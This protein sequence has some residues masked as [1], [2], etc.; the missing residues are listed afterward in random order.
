MSL[1]LLYRYKNI[2]L[3]LCFTAMS[4]TLGLFPPSPLPPTTTAV[5]STTSR[6][7]RISRGKSFPL[8]ETHTHGHPQCNGVLLKRLSAALATSS[9][10]HTL[11]FCPPVTLLM[12][13]AEP[14]Q[15][16]IMGNSHGCAQ[17]S[18]HSHTPHNQHTIRTSPLE[19]W[20]VWPFAGRVPRSRKDINCYTLTPQQNSYT[21]SQ[22]CR[23]V[24]PFPA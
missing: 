8:R 13:S 6:D 2:F 24:C 17:V 20:M 23:S 11:V 12:D 10:Y 19:H 21:L 5:A 16:S 1:L 14:P 15:T 4:E 7:S 22:F 18:G 3:T 9:P